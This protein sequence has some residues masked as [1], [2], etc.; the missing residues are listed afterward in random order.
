MDGRSPRSRLHDF[1]NDEAASLPPLVIILGPTGAGKTAAAITLC[2]DFGG[3]II[4]ADSM[5]V[6]R[7]FDI[8]TAK[9]GRADSDVR[10]HLIDVCEP[11]STFSAA[12]FVSAALAI[13]PEIDAGARL[14]VIAGGTGLYIRALMR[15]IFEGPPRD[16][17]IRARLRAEAAQHGLA[18][19][20]ARLGKIDPAYHAVIHANDPVRIIRA[21]EVYELTGRPLSSHFAASTLRLRGRRVLKVG[22]MLPRP[23]LYAGIDRRADQMIDAGLV[24][25]VRGLLEAGVPRDAAAFK[26][27]GYRQVLEFL[28]SGRSMDWL[29]EEIRKETR[30]YAKRQLTWFRKEQGVV[31]MRSDL[32]CSIVP[33]VRHWLL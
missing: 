20:H 1:E 18:H 19:L 22:L 12:D 4:S 25:E 24:D 23:L 15:G 16:E 31:W 27:V 3:E 10:H 26:G 2:R 7:G 29:R 30:R 6:Y 21:I 17:R 14:P 32:S 9:P 8:G 13:I 33:L 11:A 28:D 5:Q